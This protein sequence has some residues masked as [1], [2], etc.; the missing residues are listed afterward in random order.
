VEFA[1]AGI[2][3]KALAAMGTVPGSD[4]VIF[5]FHH[6]MKQISIA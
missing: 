1:E 4:L 6:H 5:G 3:V 2:D